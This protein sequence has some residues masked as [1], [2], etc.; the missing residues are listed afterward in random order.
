MKKFGDK[1][2]ELL[3]SGQAREYEGYEDLRAALQQVR[4]ESGANF[5]YVLSPADDEGSPVAK[6]EGGE[7][8]SFLIT[9]DGSAEADDWANSY[10][11]EIQFTEAWKGSPAAARSCWNVSEKEQCW[12][13]FAPVHDSEGNVVCILGI[14]YP[15][16]TVGQANPE[17]NRHAPEWN[18]IK[19]EITIEVPADVQAMRDKVAALAAK[20]AAEL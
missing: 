17:W 20:Y 1:Y 8:T 13:G 7:G 2:I 10:G 18:G 15:D 4:E 9:V 12:S 19:T 11:W 16:F 14:D 3:A 5:V 6:G